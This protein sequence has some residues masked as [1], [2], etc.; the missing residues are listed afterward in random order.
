MSWLICPGCRHKVDSRSLRCSNCD[1]WVSEMILDPDPYIEGPKRYYGMIDGEMYDLTIAVHE[2][3]Q[4]RLFSGAYDIRKIASIDEFSALDIARDIQEYGAPTIYDTKAPVVT[5][6]APRCPTCN[7]T[8]VS[9][10][11]IG[12]RAMASAFLGALS[13]EGRAQFRCNKCGYMW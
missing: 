4:G 3:K 13:V 7:S 12:S 9:K 6:P 5:R 8:S 11:G 1:Y 2:I 10:I